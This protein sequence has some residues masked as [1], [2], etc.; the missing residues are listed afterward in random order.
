[1]PVYTVAVDN[2]GDYSNIYLQCQY[3]MSWDYFV[4]YTKA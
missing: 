1:M 4:E 2:I 3:S